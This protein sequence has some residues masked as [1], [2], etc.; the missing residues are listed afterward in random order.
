[1]K[2]IETSNPDLWIIEP[3]VFS[4]ERGYFMESY[5]SKWFLEKGISVDF[6]QDN[7]SKSKK[8][9]VRGLHFQNPPYAQG[10]LIRVIKGAVLDVVVDLRQSSPCYGQYVMVE[11]SEENKRM[12]WMPEGFAHG[13]RTLRDNTIFSYKCTAHY[14]KQSEGSILWCDE[15]LNIPWGIDKPILS[16]KDMQSPRFADFQSPFE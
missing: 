5:N 10:K 12:F 3:S 13:F 14:N 11:L 2:F 1:M 7:E 4:D 9:V 8:D 6:V 16:E 15:T